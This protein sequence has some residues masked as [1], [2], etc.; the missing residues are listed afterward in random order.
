MSCPRSSVPSGCA[1]DGPSSLAAKSISLIGTRQTSGPS[2]TAARMK[3]RMTELT[4]ASR[5]LRKRRHASRPGENRA[6]LRDAAVTAAPAG[7]SAVRDAGVKPAIEDI[8]N[9]VEEDDEAG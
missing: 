6:C 9:E 1:Q 4:I 7:G 2:S 5:C 8:G 3:P